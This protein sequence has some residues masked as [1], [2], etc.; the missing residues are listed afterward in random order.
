MHMRVWLLTL[1]LLLAP[2]LSAGETTLVEFRLEDQFRNE[3]SHEDFDDAVVLLIGADGGGAEFNEA[4]STAI[5]DELAAH[6]NYPALARMPYADL[7][8]VPFF[9]KAYVRGLMPEAQ[10]DWILMDW[11]GKLAKAYDFTPGETNV[12]VF[13]QQGTLVTRASGRELD[14]T[15]VARI[16]QV[17]QELLGES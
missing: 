13:D 11:R 14:G 9:A 10:D 8:K 15:V 16:V 17:L 3:R 6:P 2:D 1:A 12:L 4:W 5:H 7:R